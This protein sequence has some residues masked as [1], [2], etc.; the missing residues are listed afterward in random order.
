MGAVEASQGLMHRLS[1]WNGTGPTETRG[2]VGNGQV[3]QKYASSGSS[4]MK[5]RLRWKQTRLGVRRRFC[6]TTQVQQT[7]RCQML[8]GRKSLEE[9]LMQKQSYE[10]TTLAYASKFLGFAW[11]PWKESSYVSSLSIRYWQLALVSVTQ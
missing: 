6:G 5:P 3:D 8:L 2:M 10:W 11:K 9:E 4:V 7:M 1:K